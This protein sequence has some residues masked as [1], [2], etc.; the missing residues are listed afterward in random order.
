MPSPLAKNTSESTSYKPIVSYQATDTIEN[1]YELGETYYLKSKPEF[2]LSKF[3]RSAT[4]IAISIV[5]LFVILILLGRNQGLSD[6]GVISPVNSKSSS[7]VKSMVEVD[8]TSTA[9]AFCAANSLCHEMG[10][11]GECCPTA[12]GVTL[13][14]CY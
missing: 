5:V 9:S 6:S 7:E 1:D 10:L 13:E 12:A 8:G 14:C 4:P 3:L 11:T 2:S